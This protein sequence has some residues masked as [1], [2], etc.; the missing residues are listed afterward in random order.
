MLQHEFEQLVK[1]ACQAGNLPLALDVLKQAGDDDVASVA[2]SLSGQFM[3]A[4]IDGEQRIYHVYTE[5]DAQGESQEFAEYIMNE[6]E[7]V[8]RFIAW[9]FETMFSI[10]KKQTYQAV[11]KTY[12]QP[13][14]QPRKQPRKE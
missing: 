3:I 2:S 10:K 9:F 5:T 8:I 7:D 12:I 1:Q 14:R 6:G 13:R 4:E 11:G